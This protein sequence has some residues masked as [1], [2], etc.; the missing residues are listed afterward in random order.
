MSPDYRIF[1]NQYIGLL[2]EIGIIGLVAFLG[3]IATAMI[4]HVH[5]QTWT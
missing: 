2:I 4:D 5:A 1:D 3:L